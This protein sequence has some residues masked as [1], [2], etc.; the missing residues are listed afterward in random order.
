MVILTVLSLPEV[1]VPHLSA[2][3]PIAAGMLY[4]SHVRDPLIGEPFSNRVEKSSQ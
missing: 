1:V 2:Y 3:C 4:L